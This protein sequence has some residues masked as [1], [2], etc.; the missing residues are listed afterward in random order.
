MRPESAFNNSLRPDSGTYYSKIDMI[1]PESAVNFK[2]IRPG[3][4][5]T[6]NTKIPRPISSILRPESAY[7]KEDK[8]EEEDR[9]S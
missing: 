3:S 7:I 9:A 5:V 1:R 6:F 4:A 8:E 2:K